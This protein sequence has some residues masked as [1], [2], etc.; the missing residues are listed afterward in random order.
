MIILHSFWLSLS[1]YRVRI[2]LNVKN[3]AFEECTHDL[4]KGH[5]HSAEFLQLNPAGAVPALEAP[6]RS[7]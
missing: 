3:V 5:Q 7:L 2:A 1:T 4:T 6:R